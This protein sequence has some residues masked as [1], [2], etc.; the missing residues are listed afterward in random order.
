MK[1]NNYYDAFIDS[2]LALPTD[3]RS[4][5]LNCGM[6]NSTDNNPYSYLWEVYCKEENETDFLHMLLDMHQ[7]AID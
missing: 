5:I 3:L 4:F 2:I 1:N 6:A 7:L